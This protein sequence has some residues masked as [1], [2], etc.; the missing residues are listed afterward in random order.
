[1]SAIDWKTLLDAAT[2]VAAKAYAPYSNYTV[3][4]AAYADDGRVLV[5]CNIENSSLGLTLCGE[6]GLISSLYAT[7]GGRLTAF[8][9]VH[10]DGELV[11]P[12]GRCRQL[13]LEHGGPD[14]P[15]LSPQG[16]VTL[17][18]LLPQ[19]WLD[20]VPP[21]R[22]TNPHPDSRNRHPGLVPGSP[23]EVRPGGEPT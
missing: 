15:I 7:G 1:M 8:L 5:G 10:G 23:D 2:E 16:E 9:C 6:C 18:D 12:C 22:A 11:T 21:E 4:A 19:H 13:L 14:L 17:A 20:Y 3:G